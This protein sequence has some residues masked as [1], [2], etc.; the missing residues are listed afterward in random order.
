MPCQYFRPLAILLAQA[1]AFFNYFHV[2][3]VDV[4]VVEPRLVHVPRDARHERRR[5]LGRRDVRV[6]DAVR[7][8]A[9]Y[10]WHTFEAKLAK[11]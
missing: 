3:A 11:V 1:L 9:A 6:G 10:L 8:R 4:A 5:E 7:A 2:I